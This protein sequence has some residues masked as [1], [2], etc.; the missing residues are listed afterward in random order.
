MDWVWRWV[1][2]WR[3]AWEWVGTWAQL[4][5]VFVAFLHDVGGVNDGDGLP[6]IPVARNPVDSRTSSLQASFNQAFNTVHRQH[7]GSGISIA[8]VG[9]I[10]QRTPRLVDDYTRAPALQFDDHPLHGEIG[11]SG[12]L[13]AGRMIVQFGR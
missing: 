8:A 7:K 11:Q 5:V 4:V 6:R 2:R 10:G 9:D 1:C 13:G 12:R 3:A